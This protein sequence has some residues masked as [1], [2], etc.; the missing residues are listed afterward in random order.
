[1]LFQSW[2]CWCELWRKQYQRALRS[3]RHQPW[4]WCMTMWTMTTTI[5]CPGQGW[6][7]EYSWHWSNIK[8]WSTRGFSTSLVPT[9]IHH[10]WQMKLQPTPASAMHF[11]NSVMFNSLH[12]EPICLNCTLTL[13]KICSPITNIN[14]LSRLSLTW[15]TSWAKTWFAS[16]T[17]PGAAT[18]WQWSPVHSSCCMIRAIFKCNFIHHITSSQASSV[19]ANYSIIINLLMCCLSRTVVLK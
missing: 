5:H 8:P 7:C 17:W 19:T 11:F 2:C 1:M 12:T 9:P 13:I 6:C 16:N 14:I 4:S 18:S 15:V 3:E 10:H